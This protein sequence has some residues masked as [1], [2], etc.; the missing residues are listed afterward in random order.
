MEKLIGLFGRGW[1]FV[2]RYGV[3]RLY[4]KVKERRD[5]NRAEAGYEDWL[6]GQLPDREETERQRSVEFAFSPLISILVPAYET[7]ELFLR[8]MIDSVLQQSYGRLELCIADG[9]P[10]DGVKRI[11]EAYARKDSRVR[12]RKLDENLGISGNTNAALGEASGAYVG[13][14]DHDDLLL[15]GALFEIVRALN[16]GEPADAV[17]TDEDKL[18]PERN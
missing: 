16:D 14:L 13:L 8:Q 9:S 18:D 1:R 12:Y 7:P 3:L 17:Y 10:S 15:P 11:A 2:R 5:R 6:L 4:R